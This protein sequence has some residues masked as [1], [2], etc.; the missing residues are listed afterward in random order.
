MLSFFCCF[1]SFNLSFLY[2]KA[3]GYTDPVVMCSSP[4]IGH[5]RCALLVSQPKKVDSILAWL[6][7][8]LSNNKVHST[9]ILYFH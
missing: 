9:N 2:F 1:F 6:L 3:L 5:I 8:Y 7:A 4:A